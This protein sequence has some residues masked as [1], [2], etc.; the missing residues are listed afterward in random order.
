MIPPP[1][2]FSGAHRTENRPRQ[3][4]PPW[5]YASPIHE[6]AYGDSL[7]RPSARVALPLPPLRATLYREDVEEP[8]LPAWR[9]P[10]H[11]AALSEEGRYHND[12][13]LLPHGAPLP[14]PPLRMDLFA[15]LEPTSSSRRRFMD[16]MDERHEYVDH[17]SDLQQATEALM[18]SRRGGG[19]SSSSSSAAA[20]KRSRRMSNSERGKLYR[21]RRKEYVETLEDQLEEMKRELEH[22]RLSRANSVTANLSSSPSPGV[23]SDVSRLVRDRSRVGLARTVCEYFSLFQYGVPSNSASSPNSSCA[24]SSTL[25]NAA[26]LTTTARLPQTKQMTILQALVDPNMCFGEQFG[27]QMLMEQWERYSTYHSALKFELDSLEVVLEEPSPL[28]VACATLHVRFSRTTIE[29]VFPHVLWNQELVQRLIG[30]DVAYPVTNKFYFGIDGKIKRYE[31]EVDFMAAFVRALGNSHE[32]MQLVGNALIKEQSRIGP[33]LEEEEEAARTMDSRSPTGS[34]TSSHSS[35]A[36]SRMAEEPSHPH[37]RYK[38]FEPRT[39]EQVVD[40]YHSPPCSHVAS[41]YTRDY[42]RAPYADGHPHHEY[43]RHDQRDYDRR[44]RYHGQARAV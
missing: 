24:P 41:T 27:I 22:L 6:Q 44:L 40:E 29:K 26:A 18:L 3:T 34:T 23:P 33:E 35:S 4:S 1:P 11:R 25:D 28:I 7:P 16:Q 32:A 9:P 13:P 17:A 19:S 5:P 36:G 43:H 31:T 37:Q 14:P 21:S 38:Q 8:Q 12:R 39:T 20:K 30:L 10:L 2:S 42:D 15:H